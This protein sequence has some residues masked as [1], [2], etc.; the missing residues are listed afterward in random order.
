MTTNDKLLALRGTAKAA[1][2]L[3]D[4]RDAFDADAVLAVEHTGDDCFA[5][6]VREGGAEGHYVLTGPEGWR[7]A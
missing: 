3:E 7:S 5:L 4:V 2:L 1:E 6:T